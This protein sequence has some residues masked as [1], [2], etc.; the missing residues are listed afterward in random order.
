MQIVGSIL[1]LTSIQLF[2]ALGSG[3]WIL[4]D[5]QGSRVLLYI[6]VIRFPV[7]ASYI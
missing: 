1:P 4:S 6:I 7:I 3:K 5:A 2:L